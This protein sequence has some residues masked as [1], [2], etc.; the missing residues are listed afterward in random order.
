MGQKESKFM[1]SQNFQKEG[2]EKKN[3]CF[4]IYFGNIDSE[5]K[6]K[7]W[8]QIEE[9]N[10]KNELQKFFC[11]PENLSLKIDFEQKNPNEEISNEKL[12]V[13]QEPPLIKVSLQN[14]KDYICDIEILLIKAHTIEHIHFKSFLFFPLKLYLYKEEFSEDNRYKFFRI[15]DSLFSDPLDFEKNLLY[16]EMNEPKV[17]LLAYFTQESDL[18]TIT[19]FYKGNTYSKQVERFTK[20]EE[21]QNSFNKENDTCVV[22]CSNQSSLRIDERSSLSQILKSHPKLNF[23]AEDIEDYYKRVNVATEKPIYEIFNINNQKN[24]KKSFID[25]PD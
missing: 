8:A 25:L 21:I 18:L 11:I 10:F 6:I 17:I 22:L 12:F 19:I 7:T 24:K 20:I 15:N 1:F 16:Y 23:L 5:F 4:S 14:P 9:N 3:R 2:S 13:L